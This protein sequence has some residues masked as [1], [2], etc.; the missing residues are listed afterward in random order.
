MPFGDGTGPVN[1]GTAKKGRRFAGCRR[2]NPGNQDNQDNQSNQSNQGT[3]NR[4]G[5]G[6]GI[7]CG[8]G[9]RRQK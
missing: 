1:T 3:R 2:N 4:P 6:A 9:R 8:M 5:N 7:G